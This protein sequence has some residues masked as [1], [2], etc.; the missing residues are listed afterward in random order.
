MPDQAGRTIYFYFAFTESKQGKTGL[1]VT[2]NVVRK[3]SG[4]V[5]VDG[6]TASALDA[7]KL[8]GLYFGSYTTLA[9]TDSDFLAMAHTATT[10]V[11]AQDVYALQQV[12]MPW[13][14]RLDASISAISDSIQASL[15]TYASGP[16][17]VRRRGDSWSISIT[18]LGALTGYTSLWFTVKDGADDADSAAII[19]IKKNA[20]GT[21]DGLIYLNGAAGTAG[22]GSITIDDASAGDI[23]IALDEA[24]TLLLPHGGGKHY[25]IQV[26]ISGTVTTLTE[27]LFGITGDYTRAVT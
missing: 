17:I 18:G 3:S 21:G 12:G 6:G 1:T 14:E 8:P 9:G 4:A 10:S 22:Q 20:S 5:V 11:D 13:I 26:L 27:A 25:D 15:G 19:Q 2:Y 23:T 7:T 16:D 24:A